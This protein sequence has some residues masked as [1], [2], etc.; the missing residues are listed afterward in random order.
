MDPL[1]VSAINCG[2]N[3]V[4]MIYAPAL[5]SSRLFKMIQSPWTRADHLTLASQS[6]LWFQAFLSLATILLLGVYKATPHS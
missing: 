1:G 5:Q 3:V 4:S 6:N 2:N